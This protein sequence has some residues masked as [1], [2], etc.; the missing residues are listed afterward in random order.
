MVPGCVKKLLWGQQTY[1]M[2][3]VDQTAFQVI[4]IPL[5]GTQEFFCGA[6]EMIVGDDVLQGPALLFPFLVPRR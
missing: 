3:K 2:I 5:E 1:L 6:N 4:R